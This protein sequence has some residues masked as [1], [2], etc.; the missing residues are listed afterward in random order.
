MKTIFFGRLFSLC[1][2]FTT[3]QWVFAES[4]QE[5]QNWNQMLNRLVVER[6]DNLGLVGLGAMV[7]QDGK[8]I[9]SAVDGERKYRSGV[10]LTDQDKWHIGSITK[11]FT[12]TM[13][14]RLVERDELTWNTTIGDVYADSTTIS[15]SWH[16]VTV[17]QLLTHTSGAS[18]D[19][20]PTLSYLFRKPAEGS[21]RMAAR[22]ALILKFLKDKEPESPAGSR[23]FYSNTGV[24]IAGVMAE[25]ITGLPWEELIRNEIFTPLGIRSGGFGSPEDQETKLEQPRGHKSFLGFIV[26]VDTDI[27]RPVLAPA[28]GIHIALEDLLIYANDHLQGEAGRG[29]LLKAETYQHLHKPILEDYAY[30]WVVKPHEAWANEPVIFHAGS[31]GHWYAE[32]AILP[33]SNAIIAIVSNDL[34]SHPYEEITRPIFEGAVR[35]LKDVEVSK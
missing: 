34:R 6:R 28:G 10:L 30:G 8:V 11:S 18:N 29:K 26:A 24:L 25:K 32:L 17:E 1:L 16:S 12:A 15:E 5:E 33:D 3:S 14:A 31:N 7:M 13:I 2:M 23:F 9:A 22:E 35:L 20:S 27:N 4:M 21:A 19:F